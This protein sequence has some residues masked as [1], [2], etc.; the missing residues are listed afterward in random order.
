[1]PW[2]NIV[3]KKVKLVSNLDSPEKDSK[4]EYSTKYR[5][6]DKREIIN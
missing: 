1:M 2:T 4:E 3:R 6:Y 5:L